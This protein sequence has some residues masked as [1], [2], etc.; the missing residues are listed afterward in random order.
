MIPPPPAHA[1]LSILDGSYE[2]M[3][4]QWVQSAEAGS[5]DGREIGVG[6]HVAVL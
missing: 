1:R 5:T 6:R 3:L 2:N 4:S